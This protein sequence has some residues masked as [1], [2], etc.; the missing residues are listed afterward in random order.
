MPEYAFRFTVIGAGAIGLAIARELSES[1][2]G[3][4]DVLVVEKE[5][6]FGRGASSRS[7]EVIH[8]GI[9][10]PAGSLKHRLCVEGRRLLYGFCDRHGVKYN[11]CGKLIVATVAGEVEGLERLYARALENGVENVERLSAGEALEIEPDMN[12]HSAIFSR[13]TGVFDSHG[14]MKS[15]EAEIKANNGTVLYGFGVVSVRFSGGMYEVGLQDGTTFASE[16][17]IN[18]AGL[19]AP[20][21]AMLLGMAPAAQFPCKGVYFAYSGRHTCRHLVYPVPSERLAGLGI[22]ATIDLAGRLRFG[23]D[24]EYIADIDD[25]TVDV[26]KTGDFC[27]GAKKIFRSID[28]DDLAPDAAGIRPKIQGPADREVKDFYIADEAE[29]GYPKFINLLGMESPGLTS[30]LAIGKYVCGLL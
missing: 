28:C 6:T 7:S 29:R 16:Y 1:H 11:K 27:A 26:L 21:I 8:S 12:V 17:V 19:H 18:S 15:M 22:H 23:P 25:Y 5:N 2:R 9:Y 10:Y 13:E 14:F 24:A 20:G 4:T 3:E 30:S